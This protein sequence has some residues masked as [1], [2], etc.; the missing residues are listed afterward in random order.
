MATRDKSGRFTKGG[1]AASGNTETI[2]VN[3][4]T[5][6]RPAKRSSGASPY[7]A[8]SRTSRKSRRSSAAGY[9]P[10]KSGMAGAGLALLE[11]QA[12][13][14]TE[15]LP[16]VAGTKYI[17]MAGVLH[18]VRDKVPG[19]TKTVE[20]AAAIAGYEVVTK[21]KGLAMFGLAGPSSDVDE[22]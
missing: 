13:G 12:P 19:G 14:L 7:V 3:T 16:T 17:A 9:A 20:A 1:R 10:L 2:I 6:A 21:G 5:R 8:A 15:K 11:K 4:G 18:L 22:F